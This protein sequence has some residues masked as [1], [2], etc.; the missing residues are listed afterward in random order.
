[1][2]LFLSIGIISAS[3]NITLSSDDGNVDFSECSDVELI[4]DA[5][6][7]QVDKITN[8]SIKSNALSV[9]YGEK[10]ALVG[11]L[12]DHTGQ[13]LKNKKLTVSFDGK[14]YTRITD[15]NGKI[16]LNLNLKPNTY[17]A[18]IN[19]EGD[20]NYSSSHYSSIIKVLKAPTSLN[21]NDYS[22]Y[23]NSDLF[24]KTKVINKVTGKPISGIKVLFKVY[25][26]KKLF[27]S[28]YAKTDKNG[29]ATLNKNLNVGLYRVHVSISSN[30]QKKNALYK[31]SKNTATLKIKPTSEMGCCSIYLQ[32]TSSESLTGFRRDSTYAADMTIKPVV[33]YGRLAIKQYK[34]NGGYSFH[35]ITTADGWHIATGSADAPRTNLA[36]EKL[37]GSMV[38]SGVIQQAKLITIRKYLAS[39]GYN[40]GHVAI[41][42]PT[43]LYA[44][45]WVNGYKIG[46][47]NPG[48][49]I[50]VPNSKDSFRFGKYS[51]FDKNPVNAAVKIAATDPYGV[52][53]RD[54]VVYHW[55]ATTKE[56]STTS[57]VNVYSSND[58]GK[59]VG[60]STG[61][62]KDNIY[63][64]NV[65]Y[66]KN[67]LPIAPSKK[68]LGFYKFGYIN[69]FKIQTTVTAPLVVA[70]LNNSKIFKITVKNKAT[71]KAIHGLIIKVKLFTGSNYKTYTFKTN[72][73]VV[74]FNTSKLSVGVH[75]IVIF[76]GHDRYYASKVSRIT[77]KN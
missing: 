60:R 37:A 66:S 49:Y 31:N 62:L 13:P 42:S 32:V 24:F 63:F 70:S 73:G 61:Y 46:K 20:S 6:E 5:G 23:Y 22:T 35:S 3:E 25:S 56:G 71:N 50:S 9:Y 19:F 58:N 2:L 12:K 40:I 45:V 8:T 41:K 17:K 28:V 21:V 43:G 33:W 47:L 59:L 1:M 52:N 15:K 74:N 76:S 39:I 14:K 10:T 7:A 34:T 57:L 27:K 65:F 18:N 11:Y 72:N 38:K 64:R 36:I 68:F 48:E 75:N 26:G 44:I 30:D 54:I 29:I 67:S 53:R 77:I 16:V 55:K 51:S 4:A 69:K